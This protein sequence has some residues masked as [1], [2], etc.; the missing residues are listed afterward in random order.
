MISAGKYFFRAVLLLVLFAAFSLRGDELETYSRLLTRVESNF[1]RAAFARNSSSIRT[2]FSKIT[3]DLCASARRIYQLRKNN[4]TLTD[5]G[6]LL[7]LSLQLKGLLTNHIAFRKKRINVSGMKKTGLAD[8]K[9]TVRKNSRERRSYIP[10]DTEL[11]LDE[12]QNHL[13]EI[14][15]ENL[16]SLESKFNSSRDLTSSQQDFLMQ[17]AEK[18]YSCLC[19]ARYNILMLRQKDPTFRPKKKKK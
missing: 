19:K 4:E 11:K 16:K 12:Y 10:K 1:W 14:K 3:T 15:D 8:F 18:F 7:S 13:D 6:D 5:S 9:K 2:S 17:T